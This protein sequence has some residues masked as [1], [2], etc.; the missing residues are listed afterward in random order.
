MK[1]IYYNS[2]AANL[3]GKNPIIKA[4]LLNYIYNYHKPN[5]RKGPGSPACISLSQF[6]YR[7]MHKDLYI[8]KRSFIHKIL[9]DLEKAG[10]IA[11]VRDEYKRP[12]YSVSQQIVTL[13]ND[14]KAQWV[15]FDLEVA[16]RFNIYTA[17]VTRYILHVI[18]QSPKKVAYN[19][20]VT[21][22]AEVSCVSPAQI[23]RVIRH[24][25]AEKIVKRDKSSLKHPTR[26]LC[27]AR[28]RRKE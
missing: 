3:C 12:V 11:I 15:N 5:I 20:S 4:V 19:L 1:T 25:E 22:M 16:C 2:A 24:L 14:E 17:I 10:H 8:W 9:K 21:R 23:Y 27:L 7:Y 28:Y 13:L 26:A 18:D 6:V